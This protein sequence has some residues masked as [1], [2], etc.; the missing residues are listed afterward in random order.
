MQCT[1]FNMNIYNFLKLMGLCLLAA[2]CVQC[3][4]IHTAQ[5][6]LMDSQRVDPSKDVYRVGFYNVENLF[7]TIDSPLRKDD[8]F[9]PQGRNQWTTER[10]E[11]KLADLAKIIDKMGQPTLLGLSE[12][13]NSR[14][15]RDLARQEVLKAARYIPI[16]Q[17]SP[18]FR[19]IDVALMYK[20]DDFKVQTSDLI[21]IDFPAEIVEDYTTRDILYVQ[22]VLDGF[23]VIHI[24]VNHWPSRRGGAEAS[25]PKRV[26]VAQ[27]L[28]KHTDKILADDPDAHIVMMG[29]FNDE[30]D[31]KS[32]KEILGGDFMN[33]MSKLDQEGKGTYNYKGDWSMLDH[34]IVSDALASGK[35]RLKAL[36]GVVFREEW[37]MFKSEKYGPTPNRTY[38]GPNY[39]GGF[40]DHLPVYVDLI[41]R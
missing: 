4:P 29:D 24:F 27:Q 22:G 9:T 25:E 16:H 39:Y 11:K 38:G 35:W 34:I 2:M 28:R 30:T 18:D 19:G 13:E 12:V 6:M 1:K 8:D 3:S 31:N 40:S 33:C 41:A 7:D 17:Q 5:Q 36:E 10:Y 15:C 32:T 37:M 14:V 26:Y 20:K 23:E 21:R